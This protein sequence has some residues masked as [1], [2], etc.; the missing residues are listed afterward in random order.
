VGFT[1]ACDFFLRSPGEAGGAGRARGFEG[2]EA[3]AVRSAPSAARIFLA[4]SA[5]SVNAAFISLM[6]GPAPPLRFTME[7]F[8]RLRY[9]A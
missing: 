5:F 6:F 1:A 7:A 8:T 2:L 4:L 3:G 9:F